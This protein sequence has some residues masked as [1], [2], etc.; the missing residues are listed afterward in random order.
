MSPIAYEEFN[1]ADAARAIKAYEQL[2]QRVA[3]THST[4][5]N[6]VA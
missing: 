6:N 5:V 1:A 2:P 3:A 4:P